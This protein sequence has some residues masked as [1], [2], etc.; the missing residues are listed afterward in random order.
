MPRGFGTA[1]NGKLKASEWQTL[2][3]IHLPLAVLDALIDSEEVD[4]VLN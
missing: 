1:K 3:A 2:F 4:D